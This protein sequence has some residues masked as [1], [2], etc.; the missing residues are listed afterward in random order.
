M[1]ELSITQSVLDI[2]LDHAEQNGAK[3]ISRIVLTIGA[4]TM[5]VGDCVR[6]YFDTISKGTLAEGAELEIIDV[7]MRVKCSQCNK[8]YESEDPIFICPEC[9]VISSE[10]IS[11]KEL[12]V[13]SIIIEDGERDN[14]S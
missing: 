8:V 4:M 9:Q 1:H 10:I 12:D 13:T 5:V 7:P 3:H 14:G 2:A 6:F 11:G